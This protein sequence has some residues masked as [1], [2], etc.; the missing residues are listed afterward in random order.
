G[1][2]CTVCRLRDGALDPV[3]RPRQGEVYDALMAA[4]DRLGDIAEAAMRMAPLTQGWPPELRITE[5]DLGDH[6]A[7][8]HDRGRTPTTPP[9]PTAAPGDREESG[10]RDT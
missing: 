10:V 2:G 6:V 4:V 8:G 1:R 9:A 3:A 7:G 5:R